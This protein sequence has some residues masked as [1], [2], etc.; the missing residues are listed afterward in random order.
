MQT[1]HYIILADIALLAVCLKYIFGDLSLFFKAIVVHF[2]SNEFYEP[3]VFK[4]WEKR[5]DTQHKM[6]ILYAC[7]LILAVGTLL[8]YI[9]VLSPSF[10][11][12]VK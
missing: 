12:G 7:A 9:F 1:I 3:A 11:A 5:Y 10:L 2:F 6:N 8:L 4:R